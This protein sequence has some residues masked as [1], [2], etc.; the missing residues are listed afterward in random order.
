ML[1]P[2]KDQQVDLEKLTDSSID[3]QIAFLAEV[4]PETSLELITKY[5]L[6][7]RNVEQALSHLRSFEEVKGAIPEESYFEVVLDLFPECDPDFILSL[8]AAHDGLELSELCDAVIQQLNTAESR[9]CSGSQRKR[10]FIPV[11]QM[12]FQPKDRLLIPNF[13]YKEALNAHSKSPIILHS[14]NINDRRAPFKYY[15][16]ADPSQESAEYYRSLID[17]LFEERNSLYVKAAKAFSHSGFQGKSA[18]SFYSG[19]ARDL[20]TEI[21]VY[22]KL[23]AHATFLGFNPD[24]YSNQIDLHGLSVAEALPITS[25]FLKHH[26]RDTDKYEHVVIITGSGR[27]SKNG[28]RLRPEVYHMLKS[29]NWRFNFDSLCLFKVFRK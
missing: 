8:I 1:F 4:F 9:P 10:K 21:E 22:S 18:A 5:L 17:S 12:D 14:H 19:L 2:S 20:T 27:R 25:A 29:Q 7:Y 15:F 13:T 28:V 16:G 23:A 11:S 6:Q 26:L 3:D 24:P